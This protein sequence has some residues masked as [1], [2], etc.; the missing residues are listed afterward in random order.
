MQQSAEEVHVLMP[1]RLIEAKPRSQHSLGCFWSSASQDRIHGITRCNPQ[2]QKHQRGNQPKHQRRQRQSGGRVAQ[3]FTTPPHQLASCNRASFSRPLP[4]N[5]GV[6]S[7]G[8]LQ[9]LGVTSQ[10]GM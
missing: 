9:A 5:S 2:E 4:S 1:E 7:S 8:R 6:A 3:Q 10:T